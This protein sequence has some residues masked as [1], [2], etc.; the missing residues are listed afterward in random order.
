MPYIGDPPPWDWGLTTLSHRWQT[1]MVLDPD[2]GCSILLKFW[3]DLRQGSKDLRSRSLSDT[4]L[5]QRLAKTPIYK[6][7]GSKTLV[8]L[9]NLLLNALQRNRSK[10]K[11]AICKNYGSRAILQHVVQK[12]IKDQLRNLHVNYG[13]KTLISLFTMLHNA[14]QRKRSKTKIA[15]CKNYGSKTLVILFNLLHKALQRNRSKT[16]SANCKNCGSQA[17]FSCPSSSLP[18][19]LTDWLSE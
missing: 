3:R 16:K 8:T 2:N 13:S 15:I 7:Y 12:E 1:L 4:L 6:I 14:V 11:F 19:Y 10:T 9:F 5:E 18:I 17:I